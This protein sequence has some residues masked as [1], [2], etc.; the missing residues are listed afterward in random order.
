MV[1]SELNFKA[2]KIEIS[3]VTMNY[4]ENSFKKDISQA[5]SP[6]RLLN[7]QNGVILSVL[8]PCGRKN[9]LRRIIKKFRLSKVTRCDRVVKSKKFTFSDSGC[10]TYI[11]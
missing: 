5:T 1:T 11:Y 10:V 2:S 9:T 6:N 8:S 3:H 7:K 4:L